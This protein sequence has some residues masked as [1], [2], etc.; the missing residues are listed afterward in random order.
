MEQFLSVILS[1][2]KQ[3][4]I[5]DKNP[6]LNEFYELHIT[7]IN[8]SFSIQYQ[9]KYDKYN[10][11]QYQEIIFGRTISIIIFELL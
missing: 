4:K 11:I 9:F 5:K 3:I 7:I 8:Q 6:I 10:Q 1:E 2:R